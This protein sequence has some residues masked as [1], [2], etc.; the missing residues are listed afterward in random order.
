MTTTFFQSPREFF[1][2]HRLFALAAVTWLI[3]AGVARGE[4]VY[5]DVAVTVVENP[6]LTGEVS[7]WEVLSWERPLREFTYMLDHALWGYNPLGYHLQNF[8]WHTADVLLLYLLLGLIGATPNAAFW[9]AL[10]FAVHPVNAESVA[11]I[12]GRK[13]MLCFFFEFSCVGLYLI[14]VNDRR[15][16][17]WSGYLAALVCLTLALLSKQVAVMTPLFLALGYVMMR[18]MRIETISWKRMALT[19]AP[20]VLLVVGFALLRYPLMERLESELARGAYFDPAARDVAFSPLSAI[21]TPFATFGRSFFLCLFPVDLTVEH[22]F[23]PVRSISDWRWM[24]GALLMAGLACA[25][26]LSYKRRPEIA[27]GLMWFFIAWLPVSGALP[28]SYLVADRYLYIPCAGF[29]LALTQAV[30]LVPVQRRETVTALLCLIVAAFSMRAA[31]RSFDWRNEIALWES[32]VKARP[33]YAKPWISLANANAEAGRTDK[34]FEYWRFALSL[35]PDLPQVWVNMGQQK[36]R[37]GDLDAAEAYY[38]QAL[39][40]LPGYGTA[41]YNLGMVA[42]QRDELDRALDYFQQAAPNMA[43]KR[44]GER[45]QGMAYYQIAR[46]LFTRGQREA[47][48]ANLVRAEKLAPQYAPVYNLRGM[49]TAN[50]EQARLAFQQAVTLDPAYDEAWFNLGVAEWT[51]G[52]VKEAEAAWDEAVRLDPTLQAPIDRVKHDSP[53]KTG[54]IDAH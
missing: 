24:G 35:D 39:E 42:L 47:A 46:L 48:Q 43:G 4:F 52:R 23:A 8:A 11:W 49:L 26:W 20:F 45:R 13:E 7:P 53:Q 2:P 50:P 40:L 18:R 15:F 1:S 27:L 32:A 3:Y 19:V 6:A 38:L 29:A 34:A 9:A 22:A 30:S 54:T 41:L 28:L 21:L 31:V 10:L 33:F 12:S 16:V 25:S 14:S 5:D 37:R 44:N 51:T 36:S 17:L